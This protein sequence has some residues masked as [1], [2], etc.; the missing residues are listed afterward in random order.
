MVWRPRF[1]L[2]LIITNN[3]IIIHKPEQKKFRFFY[4]IYMNTL[5]LITKAKLSIKSLREENNK[6]TSLLIEEGWLKYLEDKRKEEIKDRECV[7]Y[8]VP[9]FK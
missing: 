3:Y 6:S 2:L 8:K 7:T 9:I 5:K 4:F 1:R